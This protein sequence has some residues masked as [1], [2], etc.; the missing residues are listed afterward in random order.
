MRNMEIFSPSRHTRIRTLPP[1]DCNEPRS[2]LGHE[3]FRS[4]NARDW[5][6]RVQSRRR[7]FGHGAPRTNTCLQFMHRGA[8]GGTAPPLPGRTDSLVTSLSDEMTYR[9]QQ[10][11]ID[12]T[13]P[14]WVHCPRARKNQQPPEFH[15][16]LQCF[17]RDSRRSAPDC[18]P[19]PHCQPHCVRVRY[20]QPVRSQWAMSPGQEYARHFRKWPISW[21]SL[22]SRIFNI[23][24]EE[25]RFA[26]P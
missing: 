22:C 21:P 5:R 13:Q 8:S 11:L 23:R 9:N 17:V 10:S 18:C 2:G 14:P 3:A 1:H 19:D 25:T 6:V 12:E 26:V 24:V 15:Q 20:G 16:L 4:V 7:I